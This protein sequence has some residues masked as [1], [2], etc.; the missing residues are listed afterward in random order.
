MIHPSSSED[1]SD[2]E[3]PVKEEP[4]P[5]AATVVLRK[6]SV[7]SQAK[8]D[9]SASFPVSSF[10]SFICFYFMCFIHT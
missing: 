8:S 9:S 4:A 2:P 5:A 10:L 1:E 6:N 3:N 7:R